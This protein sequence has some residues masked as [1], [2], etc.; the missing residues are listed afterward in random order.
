MDAFDRMNDLSPE[1][2]VMCRQIF[3]AWTQTQGREA[4]PEGI[5]SHVRCMGTHHMNTAK[6][7]RRSFYP[8]NDTSQCEGAKKK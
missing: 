5:A 4:N 6:G 2:R 3:L 7:H 8:T 1:Q